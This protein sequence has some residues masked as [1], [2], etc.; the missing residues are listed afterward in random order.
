MNSKL[1]LFR[2]VRINR[3]IVSAL[4]DPHDHHY[5]HNEVKPHDFEAPPTSDDIIKIHYLKHYSHW[6]FQNFNDIDID[7]YRYWLRYRFEHYGTETSPDPVNPFE[8]APLR[9]TIFFTL[10]PFI[11]AFI[12]SKVNNDMTRRKNLKNGQLGNFQQTQF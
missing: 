1:A 3:H 11:L 9:V 7:S 2:R 10:A 8:R 5:T 12:F 4:R 6:E